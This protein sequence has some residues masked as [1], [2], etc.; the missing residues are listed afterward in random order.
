MKKT[1]QINLMVEPQI[2]QRLLQKSKALGLTLT[3][4]I[5]KIANEPVCF[6]DSNVKLILESLKLKS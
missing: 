5:E 6:M 1:S 4:Y 2:K 3:S